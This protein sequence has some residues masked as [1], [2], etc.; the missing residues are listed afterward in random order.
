MWN[1]IPCD[2]T[3][4]SP[5][6]R[7]EQQGKVQ[8]LYTGIDDEFDRSLWEM[9]LAPPEMSNF[10]TNQGNDEARVWMER[11]KQAESQS[12]QW[13][14]IVQQQQMQSRPTEPVVQQLLNNVA[15]APS[16]PVLQNSN[17][18]AL[19]AQIDSLMTE[20]ARLKANMQHSL[21][22]YRV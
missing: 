20:V 12:A 9:Q 15:T 14:K 8:T 21:G 7:V 19:Q 3:H 17:Q 22:F 5:K 1:L 11:C 10:M 16:A 13:Q 18:P 4:L 2:P 6:D